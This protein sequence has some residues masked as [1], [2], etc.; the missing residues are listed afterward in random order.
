VIVSFLS[1]RHYIY[2][3]QKEDSMNIYVGNISYEVTE[4]DLKQAFEAFGLVETVKIIKDRWS[5]KP[6]GFGFI[7][8]PDKDE[9]HSAIIGLNGKNLKGRNVKINEARS[10]SE[11][12]GSGGGRGGARRFY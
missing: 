11:N 10:R 9:A 3:T 8:M 6:R 4:G 7:E 12:R 5:G 2:K 1:Y